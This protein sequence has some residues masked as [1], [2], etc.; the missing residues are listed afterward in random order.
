MILNL[1]KRANSKIVC[2]K[3][4][5][6]YCD[7]SK[8]TDISAINAVVIDEQTSKNILLRLGSKKIKLYGCICGMIF[9]LDEDDI[10]ELQQKA[11]KEK[12]WWIV[13]DIN[14]IR[15]RQN[16]FKHNDALGTYP[17][18]LQ[19][20]STSLCNAKCIMC[21]H[22]YKDMAEGDHLTF[23][24]RKYFEGILPYV[25]TVMLHGVGEPFLN[26]NIVEWI[27]FYKSFGV[28][29]STFTNMSVMTPEIKKAIGEN[30]TSLHISCDGC[31]KETFE[32]IRGNLKFER[33]IE[34]VKK[35]HKEYPELKLSMHTVAMR[36]NLYQIDKFIPL[37][38]ELGFERVI[39]TNLTIDPFLQN[40]E[41]SLRNFPIMA[42]RKFSDAEKLAKKFGIDVSYPSQYNSVED[43]EED[44]YAECEIFRSIGNDLKDREAAAHKKWLER[45]ENCTAG[46][47]KIDEIRPSKYECTG[48]CDWLT[49]KAYISIHGHIAPCCSKYYLTLGSLYKSENFAD[50]WNSRTAKLIRHMEYN[51]VV[52]ELCV[53]CKYIMDCGALNVENAD[54]EF[55][56]TKTVGDL[57]ERK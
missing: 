29:L 32:H 38:A 14:K 34:N 57:F 36:Q 23:D 42:K 56:R 3:F 31:T 33:F 48:I 45:N 17:V 41:D 44:Y 30:F 11:L 15:I 20:E 55:G 5:D 18:I 43:I 1:T 26:P 54:D 52:P 28:H 46:K 6:V 40:E 37:A 27:E 4:K 12:E 25:E 47:L 13:K 21:S 16:I 49:E 7:I 53:G 22:N 35:L 2:T 51:G 19:I 39:F 9:N 24:K 50:I 8:D 10:C